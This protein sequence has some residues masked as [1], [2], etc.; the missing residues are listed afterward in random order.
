M[1]PYNPP[2]YNDQFTAY[3]LTKV[4]DL[5][6]YIIDAREGYRIPE[7]ILTLTDR[8]AQRYKV[9]VRALDM[10]N[11]EPGGGDDHRTLQPEPGRQLGLQPRSPR[12]RC[13][14]WRMT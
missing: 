1:A 8:V 4:K 12:P 2:Y 3:G 5:L 13:V 10:K 9:H 7:R 14:P 11:F 6:V